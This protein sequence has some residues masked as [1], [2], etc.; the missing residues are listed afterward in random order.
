MRG[1]SAVEDCV[2]CR[3]IYEGAPAYIV[4]ENDDVIVFLS[5]DNHPLIVTKRHV[6]DIYALDEALGAAVMAETIKIARAVKAGLAC[7]GVYL[8]QANEAAAGQ[9]VFHFHLHVYPRW[10]D[11]H[12]RSRFDVAQ[13]EPA[14]KAAL[15][16][17]LQEALAQAGGPTHDR[18]ARWH[19]VG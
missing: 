11:P 2:F 3:I 6:P 7:E 9:D 10:H 13:S 18:D 8:A 5:L 17:A 4:D 19:R 1:M 14:V 12:G 16:K 15:V